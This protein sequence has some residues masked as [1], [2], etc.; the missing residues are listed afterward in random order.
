MEKSSVNMKNDRFVYSTNNNLNVKR[1]LSCFEI[2]YQHSSLEFF[3]SIHN[4]RG[5][6]I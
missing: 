6:L 4:V 1:L 5:L 2:H 3:N